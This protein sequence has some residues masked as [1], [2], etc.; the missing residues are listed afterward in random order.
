M[1]SRYFRIH[2][3][4]FLRL[5]RPHMF[6]PPLL[7]VNEEEVPLVLM[8]LRGSQGITWSQHLPHCTTLIPLRTSLRERK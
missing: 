1:L 2:P 5:P 6:R 3:G 8:L 4:T 7:K